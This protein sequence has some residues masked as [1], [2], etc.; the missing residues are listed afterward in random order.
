[1]NMDQALQTFIV[2]SRE[3]LQDMEDG[4]LRIEGEADQS[5]SVNAIFRAAHTIKGSAGL[6]GLDDIVAFT[7]VLES[8]LDKVRGGKLA[9]DPDLVA[10]FLL[11][12]DHMATLVNHVERGSEAP[13]ADEQLAGSALVEKLSRYLD[14]QSTA[15][16]Q[17][18]AVAPPREPTV[19]SSGGGLVDN[20]NWHISL[21]FG[22][23]VLRNGMDPLSF[24]RYLGT[25]GEIVRITTITDAMP[26]AAEM[27]AESC[28]LGYEINFKSAADKAAIEGVFEFVRED[29]NIHI[30]PP[31]SRVDDFVELIRDF[32]E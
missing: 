17:Q 32:P 1:M 8:V 11:C 14:G 24:F 2:E 25:L 27:D 20:D 13:S 10:L 30:L 29:C 18:S 28:Y 9:I 4:L 6:F 7:H 16:P 23:D 5:E 3:L 22:R 26:P 31:H 19:E 15:A 12:G 21:R